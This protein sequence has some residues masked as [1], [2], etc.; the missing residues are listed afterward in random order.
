MWQQELQDIEQRWNDFSPEHQQMQ[1]RSQKMQ[2][3][4][5]RKKQCRKDLGKWA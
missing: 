5:D 4:L 1:K 2:S 3:L